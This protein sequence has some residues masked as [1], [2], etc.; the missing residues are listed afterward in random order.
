[1]I[2][3]TIIVEENQLVIKLNKDCVPIQDDF[4]NLIAARDLILAAV[5]GYEK[6]FQKKFLEEARKTPPYE[7]KF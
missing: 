6:N 4:E 3:G 1:M 7:E 5:E 2:T